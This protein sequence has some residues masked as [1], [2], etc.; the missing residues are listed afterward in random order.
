MAHTVELYLW[1]GVTLSLTTAS[2]RKRWNT[3]THLK[4]S[5]RGS[6]GLR[7]AIYP[8]QCGTVPRTR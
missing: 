3:P 4:E 8:I 7:R 5:K 6:Q 1:E 2:Q